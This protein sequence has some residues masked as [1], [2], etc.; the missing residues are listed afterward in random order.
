MTTQPLPA[1]PPVD[2]RQSEAALAIARG[3]SRCLLAHGFARLPELTLAT[4][5]RAD[6]T[7]LDAKGVIWI[8]EIKS[9]LADFR[10]DQKWWAYRDYC[11]Q[12]FFA[13][14]PD[15]PV[16]V[17]PADT[18]LIIAD[19]YG[20]ELLRPATE[21]KLSGA[22]RKEVTQRFARVAALRLHGLADPDLGLET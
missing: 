22:R 3:A 7:A 20:G 5:R 14:G 18:G 15:F 21:R 1:D 13:V 16:E 4:G 12:F 11:D 10:A 9:S 19:K 6:L 8:V 17:L 2:G